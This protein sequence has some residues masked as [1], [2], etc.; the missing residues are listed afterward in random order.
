MT[1]LSY[2]RAPK[3]RLN[4]LIKQYESE[5]LQAHNH[6]KLIR[7]ILDDRKRTAKHREKLNSCAQDFCRKHHYKIT[8]DLIKE[9]MAAFHCDEKYAS[10]MADIIKR[11]VKN[12]DRRKR[13]AQ[14]LLLSERL[15]VAEIANDFDMSRQAVYKII[16]QN[17]KDY[18]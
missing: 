11:T 5:A 10:S 14:I 9:I 8:D 4:T 7:I 1:S 6:A 16:Q 12:H 18:F 17:K 13:N 15:P 2:Y 3:S